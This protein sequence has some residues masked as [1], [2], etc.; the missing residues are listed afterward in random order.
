MSIAKSEASLLLAIK[1]AAFIRNPDYNG[2][3]S[4][5]DIVT[6]GHNPFPSNLGLASHIVLNSVTTRAYTQTKSNYKG[7]GEYINRNNNNNMMSLGYLSSGISTY[8]RNSTS[9]SE[10]QIRSGVVIIEDELSITRKKVNQAVIHTIQTEWTR[11]KFLDMYLYNR[12]FFA[13]KPFTTSILRN[14]RASMEMELYE[15]YKKKNN[16]N[17]NNY[18]HNKNKSNN[19]KLKNN[20]NSN[21]NPIDD[22]NVARIKTNSK[23]NK[24]KFNNDNGTG[25]YNQK[26]DFKFGLPYGVHHINPT[27]LTT[28]L[29]M[30]DS[31]LR[32]FIMSNIENLKKIQN[33][34][35]TTA[36]GDEV[37][38]MKEMK[39]S[40]PSKVLAF[41]NKLDD[42]TKRIIDQQQV[43]QHLYECRIASLERYIAFC[44]MFHAMAKRS[45]R[46]WLSPSWD[47]ARSQSNLRVATT[48]KEL[49][50]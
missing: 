39:N 11:Y 31:S 33:A 6:I 34:A 37:D 40:D 44:V 43:V 8:A 17:D 28:Q 15:I 9:N 45:S 12:L 4:G 26:S 24:K 47:I 18:N 20:S 46:P 30:E 35:S 29:S 14:L 7:G 36:A 3:G 50:C 16:Y 48:G 27:F 21:S 10:T 38:K 32:N 23:N 41:S 19:S 25:I 49:C 1:Q 2:S 5:P 42:E 22:I 13:E